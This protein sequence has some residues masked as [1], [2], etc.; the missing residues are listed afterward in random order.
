MTLCFGLG[1]AIYLAIRSFRRWEKKADHP[2]MAA[3]GV[4]QMYVSMPPT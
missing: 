3:K 4:R 2:F 1:L